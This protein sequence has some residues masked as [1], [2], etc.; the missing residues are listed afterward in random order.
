MVAASVGCYAAMLA[1]GCEYTGDYLGITKDE[2]IAWHRIRMEILSQ[3]GADIYACETIP[4]LMEVEAL[5]AVL[6]EFPDIKAF[7]A[8][9]CKDGVHLNSGEI[10]S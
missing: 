10:F 7:I 1:T 3:T 2:L 4:N 5:M 8:C 6:K 9:A